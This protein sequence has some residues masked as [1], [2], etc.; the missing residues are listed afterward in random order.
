MLVPYEDNGDWDMEA[1]QPP[2]PP[3]PPTPPRARRVTDK[4][5]QRYL[6]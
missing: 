1:E 2:K 6:F 5:S 4:P 3:R